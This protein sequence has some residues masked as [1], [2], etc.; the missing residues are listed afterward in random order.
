[1]RTLFLLL[2]AVATS[3][4]EAAD[5]ND[6]VIIYLLDPRIVAT[7]RKEAMSIEWN[8]A[9]TDVIATRKLN[10]SEA[11]RLRELLKKDLIDDDNVPFCGHSPAYAVSITRAG[12]PTNTVTLLVPVKLGPKL[13]I[14]GPYM[15]PLR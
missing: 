10:L 11:R 15:A 8:D 6:R 7:D 9:K 13:E 4:I 3:D 5:P 12:K 14:S 2:V 1:M